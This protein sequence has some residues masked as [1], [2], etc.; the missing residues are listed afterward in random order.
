MTYSEKL[1]DPRWQKRRL[2]IYN[3]DNFTCQECLSTTKT[4]NCHHLAY[5]SNVEPWDYPSD[6]LITLCEDC[7]K[8]VDE[9]R[10]PIEAIVVKT[11][12]LSLKDY[13]S[14]VC[15]EAVMR[16]IPD[17]QRLFFL[18]WDIG[19]GKALSVLEQ[20]YSENKEE[21]PIELI[22]AVESKS[23]CVACGGEMIFYEKYRHYKCDTCGFDIP[24]SDK[25]FEELTR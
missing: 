25:K 22:R 17:L 14:Y 15:A 4:L 1:R 19:A 23:R 10:K 8:E 21:I 16:D 12:R 20:F 9:Y 11:M 3:R 18:L 24:V 7:H 2:E 5:E 13:F 6:Y